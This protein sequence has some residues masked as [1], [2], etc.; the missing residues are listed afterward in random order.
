MNSGIG[1]VGLKVKA[2]SLIGN[3]LLRF[4]V[5]GHEIEIVVQLCNHF[6][7][8]KSTVFHHFAVVAPRGMNENYDGF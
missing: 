1:S 6:F 8:F 2:V 4:G 7:V 3:W 5:K